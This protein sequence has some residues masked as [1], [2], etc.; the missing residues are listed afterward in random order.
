[1]AQSLAARPSLDSDTMWRTMRE[2]LHR[3]FGV[4]DRDQALD[5]SLDIIVELLGADRGQ[6]VVADPDGVT[7]TIHARAGKRA[8]DPTEREEISKTIIRRAFETGEC[9]TWDAGSL[10][11]SASVGALGILAAIAAPLHRVGA[12]ATERKAVLYVDIR[13]P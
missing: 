13:D 8:V 1:M 9:V 7:R 2:L 12:G 3:V 6:V 11:T 4:I 10:P 5:D